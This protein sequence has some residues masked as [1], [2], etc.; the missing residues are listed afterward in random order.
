MHYGRESYKKNAEK[1]RKQTRQRYHDNIDKE[2]EKVRIRNRRWKKNNPIKS[3]TQARKYYYKNRDKAL[4]YKKKYAKNNPDKIKANNKKQYWK[5]RKKRL[6]HQ[7]Q[8]NKDH[9]EEILKK[10]KQYHKDNRIRENKRSRKH[11]WKDPKKRLKQ[12]KIHYEKYHILK[13]VKKRLEVGNICACCGLKD[14][15]NLSID[16]IIS[17][18]MKKKFKKYKNFDIEKLSNLQLLCHA[19]NSSKTGHKK[20]CTLPHDNPEIKKMITKARRRKSKK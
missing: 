12:E 4:A 14:I 10:R 18:T 6:A 7:K 11:Y 16:H 13:Q 1:I 15:F 19:C 17:K 3:L 5:N 9:S 8:Y 2:R 20:Y